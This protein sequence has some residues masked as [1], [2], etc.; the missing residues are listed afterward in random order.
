MNYRR[1]AM[2]GIDDLV[3]EKTKR[4]QVMLKKIEKLKCPYIYVVTKASKIGTLIF[5]LNAFTQ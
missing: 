3:I 2:R 5:D 1:E 4:I